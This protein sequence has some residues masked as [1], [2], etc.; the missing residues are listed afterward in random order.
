MS[1]RPRRSLSTWT[2][3][4]SAAR[5]AGGRWERTAA[6]PLAIAAS[7][8]SFPSLFWPRSAA[9]RYPGS[10]ARESYARPRIEV[11]GLP[12]SLASVTPSRSCQS[13]TLVPAS[14][15]VA[16]RARGRGGDRRSRLGVLPDRARSIPIVPAG[17]AGGRQGLGGL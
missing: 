14:L 3:A 6:A 7:T 10:T 8:K 17:E 1:A 13:C 11:D 15:L 2:Q 9:N 5:R 12:P 4:T 16:H